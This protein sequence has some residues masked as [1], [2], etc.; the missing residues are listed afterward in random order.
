M[1]DPRMSLTVTDPVEENF[2]PS[3][4]DGVKLYEEI[5]GPLLQSVRTTYTILHHLM[6]QYHYKACQTEGI[7]YNKHK[8]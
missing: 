2:F 3:E 1:E 6:W 5:M 7:L 8:N 4:K